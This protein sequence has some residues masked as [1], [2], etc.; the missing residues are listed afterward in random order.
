MKN[1]LVITTS[2]RKNS[3]STAL[4]EAFAEGAMEAGHNV[5]VVHLSDMNL[6][7]CRGCLAC[8][9]LHKC[10]I[11]DDMAEL[12]PEMH[13]ADVIAF[14]TPI[15]YY[16]MS[17]QM[18]TL[19]DRSNPLYGS[20]YKFRDIYLLASAA[21][22]E[23][24]VPERAVTGLSG[25]IDCYPECHFERCVFAGGVNAPGDVE[26]HPALEEAKQVGKQV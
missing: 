15:Y 5:K 3:N 19:L 18:K 9:K 1:V 25:W 13:D 2:P 16:E 4:A 11:K 17:G 23:A 7:F 24:W 12:L 20:D 14:S 22:D 21:E 10:V 26:G 6:Q 8:V